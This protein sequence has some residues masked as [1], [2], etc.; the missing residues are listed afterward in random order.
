M[1]NGRITLASDKFIYKI[2]I[3]TKMESIAGEEA[4]LKNWKWLLVARTP[5]VSSR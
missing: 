3:R 2:G 4:F 1:Q 5:I